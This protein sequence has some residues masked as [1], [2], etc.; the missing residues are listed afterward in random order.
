MG[1]IIKGVTQSFGAG[2]N[3]CYIIK[4]DSNGIHEW[5][6]TFG[7][8]EN[9]NS[10]SPGQ[11]IIQTF[12][13]MGV[14]TGYAMVGKTNSWGGGSFD[15]YII[16][17]DNDGWHQW[18]RTFGG[19][20]EESGHWIEQVYDDAGSP[21][22][23]I[24]AG[25]THSFGAGSQDHY[26][27]RIDNDGWHRWSR[28]YGGELSD[29]LTFVK[30][31]VDDEGNRAGFIAT[32]QTSS[33]GGDAALYVL[34]TDNNGI[35]EWSR[36][37]QPGGFDCGYAVRQTFK[38]DGSPDGYFLSGLTANSWFDPQD[39]CVI[40]ADRMGRCPEASNPSSLISGG[41]MQFLMAPTQDVSVPVH[42]SNA[43]AHDPS[44]P[45]HD[46]GEPD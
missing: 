16:K 42:V 40:K 22:G 11:E 7:G 25:G 17:I 35:H 24:V 2:K 20:S 26:L 34:K 14:P 46:P 15:I 30:Q 13:G 9:E 8:P 37:Y 38:A 31:V 44:V 28:T 23:Y 29:G 39:I 6:R 33:F 45:V 41:R 3:D 43:P 32:G 12:D 5:S 27:L 10:S 36:V 18:S 4:A 21:D 19:G 1:F